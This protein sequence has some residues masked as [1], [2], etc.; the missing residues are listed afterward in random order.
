[1]NKPLKLSDRQL[2]LVRT[3]SAKLRPSVRNLF[4]KCMANALTANPSDEDVRAAIDTIFSITKTR[5]T[6]EN[7][8]A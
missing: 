8:N 3:A 1:M 7:Q 5:A 2:A 6:S 4:M